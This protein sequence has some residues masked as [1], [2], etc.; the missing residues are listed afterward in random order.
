MR[1][2]LSKYMAIYRQTL[3]HRPKKEKKKK[4]KAKEY[5]KQFKVL[6]FYKYPWLYFSII[7]FRDRTVEEYRRY[8]Q[9]NKACILG[10]LSED[11]AVLDT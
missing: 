6:L 2:E 7:F 9:S 3:P 8:L 4:I 5:N 10:R 1:Q 11:K